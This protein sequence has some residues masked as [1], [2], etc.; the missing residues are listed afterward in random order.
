M[1]TIEIICTVIGAVAIILGGVW[2][3]F[4]KIFKVG[5]T[6]QRIDNIEGSVSEIKQSIGGFPCNNHHEDITKIKTILIEKYPKAFSIF[7]MK[8]SP[9]R[10]NELG[11]KLYAKI[12]GDDFINRNKSVLFEFIKQTNPLVALDVEQAANAACFSLTNTPAFNDLKDFVYNEPTWELEDGSKYDITVNDLCFVIG[13]KLRDR[14][15]DEVGL[16]ADQS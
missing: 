4:D 16:S 7:S 6:A 3:I 15:L 14:Y 11:E 5:K 13:L 2:F 9:R 8:C 1:N 12:H 10:L